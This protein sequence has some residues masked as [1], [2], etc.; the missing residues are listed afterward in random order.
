M[1]NYEKLSKLKL[2]ALSI[3]N[4]SDEPEYCYDDNIH[5]VPYWE[6]TEWS[7]YQYERLDYL[8][9]YYYACMSPDIKKHEHAKYGGFGNG[10]GKG[11]GHGIM[12]CDMS[13]DAESGFFILGGWS[14]AGGEG[15][16]LSGL[17]YIDTHTSKHEHN[18][19]N[20]KAL[21]PIDIIMAY[22]HD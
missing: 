15:H 11:Y 16:G 13:N 19:E 10:D 18:I 7:E 12:P 17:F 21:I 2:K 5:D 1:T 3:S 22:V 20:I 9:K 6:E 4:D 14:H 8:E